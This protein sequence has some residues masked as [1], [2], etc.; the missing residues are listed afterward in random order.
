[1]TDAAAGPEIVVAPERTGVIQWQSWPR[2]L[3]MLWLPLSCFVIV[4]LFPFYWMAITALKSNEE[5][6][7]FKEFNPL[8][9]HSPTLA[10]INNLL[11]E[12]DYPQ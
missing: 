5:L 12:T 1:M 10:N 8:W 6:Y 2:R 9:V 4:L 3:F 7:N 11:F